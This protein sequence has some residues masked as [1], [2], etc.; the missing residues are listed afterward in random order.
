VVPGIKAPKRPDEDRLR[1]NE[2]GHHVSESVDLYNATYSH[3][4]EAVL[5]R[6]RREAF[7][8]DIGQN[9][10]LT[11]DECRTYCAWLC[12]GPDARLLEVGCG[13]GGPALF[14][15]RTTGA[16]VTGVDI[17]AHGIAAGNAMAHH[18]QLDARVH[19]EQVDASTALPFADAHF[20]ALLCI[21]AINHLPDRLNVL[22]EWRRVVKTEGRILFTDPITMT[23][24][25]SNEEIAIRSS[26]GYFLFAPPGEDAR[27]IAEAGLQVER[28]ED[29]T[30]NMVTISQRRHDA[31][32]RAR[33]E[34][35]A[36]EG[37]QTYH[38]QQ[39]FLA[40]VHQLSSERRL[41]RYAFLSRKN[42]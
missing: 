7:G 23:G 8:E 10:W 42:A 14:I 40:M 25:L 41:S 29:M 19:F 11:A 5:A 36:L 12:L 9:S 33:E 28:V 39:R 35:L 38:G 31:R 26:I 17:N 20:D 30:E 1:D 6:V 24:L 13:S 16:R 32:M 2:K 37:E 4:G 34:L 15:A 27:L 22:R 21:D 3:F 18:Q